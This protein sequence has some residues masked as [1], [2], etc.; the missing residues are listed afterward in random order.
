MTT[1]LTAPAPVLFAGVHQLFDGYN[2]SELQ[3]Q[4]VVGDGTSF[5]AY[6]KDDNWI[7]LPFDDDEDCIDEM[8]WD[9]QLGAVLGLVFDKV[10]EYTEASGTIT[11]KEGVFTFN[12]TV[13]RS[14]CA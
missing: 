7:E 4:D 9:F 1:T 6:D 8:D 5:T 3:V 14:I 12:G 10:G 2:I 13:T 11:R